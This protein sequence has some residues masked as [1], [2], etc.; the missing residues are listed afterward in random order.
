MN[1]V[2]QNGVTS[3]ESGF[4]RIARK[5]LGKCALACAALLTAEHLAA[6]GFAEVPAHAKWVRT[7]R[8]Q[9]QPRSLALI[10]ANHAATFSP[11]ERTTRS[12]RWRWLGAR[13]GK[14]GLIDCGTASIAK[15]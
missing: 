1:P 9:G 3:G 12:L 7:W 8:V 14:P 13:K 5:S 11:K 15:S 2:Q 6:H 4:R 10:G